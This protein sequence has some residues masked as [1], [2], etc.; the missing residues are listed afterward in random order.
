MDDSVKRCRGAA[1]CSSMGSIATRSNLR[2]G[3]GGSGP[4]GL[5]QRCL[6]GG[7]RRYGVR[8]PQTRLRRVSTDL[9][10]V[11]E[12]ASGRWKVRPLRFTFQ[13]GCSHRAPIGEEES[14]FS[15]RPSVDVR[16]ARKHAAAHVWRKRAPSQ[17]RSSIRSSDRSSTR[18]SG[19]SS[20]G[21]GLGR[22]VRGRIVVRVGLR[23]CVDDPARVYGVRHLSRG[24]ERRRAPHLVRTSSRRS[25][26]A[27]AVRRFE[28]RSG[29][30]RR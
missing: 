13:A 11:P 10:G 15:K 5:S 24:S 26:A 4:R 20:T 14:A 19:R 3:G 6:V 12:A 29:R 9:L 7:V 22:R 1:R 28:L 2:A 23:V 18:P 8:P 21:I 25:A 30:R 16:F 17:G 27:H